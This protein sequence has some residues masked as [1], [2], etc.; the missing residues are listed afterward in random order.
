MFD[1]LKQY[2]DLAGQAKL[3]QNQ[4]ESEQVEIEKDG[5]KL[6]MSG[7]Q[8]I[9]SIDIN[10]DLK[11]EEIEKILPEIFDQALKKVQRIMVEKFQSENINIPNQ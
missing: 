4:L 3:L 1:K 5:I 10:S 8:K 9:I 6:V 7:N 11:H 2:K